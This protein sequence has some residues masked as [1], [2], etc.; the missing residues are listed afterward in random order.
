ML[1]PGIRPL[2]VD[3]GQTFCFCDVGAYK[4]PADT[5]PIGT[6]LPCLACEMVIPGST[7]LY[8]NS[9]YSSECVCPRGSSAQD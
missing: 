5:I 3:K 9:R 8:P 2:K 1:C 4:D 7:T 6:V